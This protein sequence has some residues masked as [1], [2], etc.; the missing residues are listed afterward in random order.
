MFW[1]EWTCGQRDP[2]HPVHL[3][4]SLF[5]FEKDSNELASEEINGKILKDSLKS[6][7]F[8]TASGQRTD[9]ESAKGNMTA[10]IDDKMTEELKKKPSVL[11][12]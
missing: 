2:L 1:K 7:R 10:F 11:R 9:R 12:D 6:R 3:L 4:S 8:E 5:C